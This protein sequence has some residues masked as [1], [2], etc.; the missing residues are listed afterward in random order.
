MLLVGG[1]DGKLYALDARSGA[2]RWRHETGGRM[3]SSPA[4]DG[5][6]AVVGSADGVVYAVDAR[7]G[8]RRWTFETLGHGLQSADFG[9]DRRTVQGSPAVAGDRVF[10]G[11]RDGFLYALERSTGRLAWKVDHEISW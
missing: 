10:I 7:T 11:A 3:R 9:F 4:A 1:G 6:L 8:A 5:D 2:V